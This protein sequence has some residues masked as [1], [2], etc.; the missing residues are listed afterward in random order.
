MYEIRSMLAYAY[1]ACFTHSTEYN[2]GTCM[3][4]NLQLAVIA[5][6]SLIYCSCLMMLF[7]GT[8]VYGSV[9][10]LISLATSTHAVHA[11]DHN[12]A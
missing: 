5:V 2:N 9:W 11:V 4:T 6:S 12:N 7:I 8:Y 3:V 1:V 10:E